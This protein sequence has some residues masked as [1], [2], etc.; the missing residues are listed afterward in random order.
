MSKVKLFTA[1]TGPY[2]LSKF[3]KD[4]IVSNAIVL[5]DYGYSTNKVSKCYKKE[6]VRKKEFN[7]CRNQYHLMTQNH[8]PQIHH[9]KSHY[10]SLQQTLFQVLRQELRQ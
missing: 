4:K 1:C 9:Q 7:I 3:F 5:V 2:F 8:C 10:F 6:R